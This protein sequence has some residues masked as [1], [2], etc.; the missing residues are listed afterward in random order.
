MLEWATP[1]VYGM[2]LFLLVLTLFIGTG[3]GTAAGSKSW[4]AIGG[5]RF[6]QPAELA[7]LAVILMLAHWLAAQREP[8][9]TLR[10]LIM[11]GIITGLPCL[12][13]LKQPDLGSAIV[14]VAILFFMLFWAGAKPSLLLLAASPGIGLVLA[15]ST[16]T[17]GVWNASTSPMPGEA[18]RDR[19]ST[20]LNSSHITISYAVF[21]LKKKRE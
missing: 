9:A 8:P 3:A 16:V 10:D 19:K 2:A 17:W 11:P 15:F 1:F 21:C 18:A 6:G 7:K 4:L 5:H 20:R 12:L 14:F 13:V